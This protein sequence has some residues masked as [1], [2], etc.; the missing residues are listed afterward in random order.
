MAVDQF[1]G[2]MAKIA[3]AGRRSVAAAKRFQAAAYMAAD[4]GV[5]L[6]DVMVRYRV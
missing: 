5:S 3:R 1:T 4:L 2:V 6:K